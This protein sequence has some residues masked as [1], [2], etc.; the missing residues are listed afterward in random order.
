MDRLKGEN[1]AL[2]KRL[3]GNRKGGEELVP[4]ESWELV[5]KENNELDDLVKQK[6][7]RLLRLQTG[8]CCQHSDSPLISRAAQ[9]IRPNLNHRCS[10]LKALNSEKQLPLSLESNLP[11]IPM[12][13]CALHRCTISA[14]HSYF[15]PH[16]RQK[17]R[18]CSSS[19][20]AKG[21]L[22]ISRS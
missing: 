4:R 18:K 7:K 17:G 8:S 11:F 10:H 6:E 1:E 9:R 2:I 13:K 16:Q 3:K 22:R 5:K 14:H 19:R 21:A 15:N 12:V 20:G